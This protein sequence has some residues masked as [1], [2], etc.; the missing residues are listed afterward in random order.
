MFATDFDTVRLRLLDRLVSRGILTR[1]DDRLLWVL[2]ARRNP[3]VDGRP[4]REVKRRVMDVL[5]S[6]TILDPRDVAIVCLADACALWSGMIHKYELVKLESRIA[7]VVRLDLIGQS[8]AR[9]IRGL[10][11]ATRGAKAR[12]F[13]RPGQP[14]APLHR[15]RE[16]ARMLRRQP[17]FGERYA[18]RREC[19][20]RRASRMPAPFVCGSRRRTRPLHS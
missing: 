19:N 1:R 12:W 2:G 13:S 3:N 15:S 17:E 16:R 14:F 20:S 18:D 8:V 7:Q 9:T 10:Q 11:D 4:L 5:L 6:E